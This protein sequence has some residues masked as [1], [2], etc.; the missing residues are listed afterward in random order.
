MLTFSLPSLNNLL[1]LS[2][3]LYIIIIF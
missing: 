2:M 3:N 1:K